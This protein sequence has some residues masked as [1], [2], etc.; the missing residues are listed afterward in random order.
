MLESNKALTIPEQAIHSEAAYTAETLKTGRDA[1]KAIDNLPGTINPQPIQKG[2]TDLIKNAGGQIEKDGATVAWDKDTLAF[3]AKQKQILFNI[4]QQAG[5][6]D[7]MEKAVDL[8]QYISANQPKFSGSGVTQ[9]VRTDFLKLKNSIDSQ[10]NEKA[11]SVGLGDAFSKANE[12][13]RMYVQP[14]H[15]SGAVDRL[16]AVKQESVRQD[17][18]SKNPTAPTPPIGSSYNAAIKQIF[19][20]NPTPQKVREVLSRMDDNG[21]K[22]MEGKFIQETVGD[23]VANP[24]NFNKNSALIKVNQLTEKYKG[25]LSPESMQT[26]DGVKKVLQK[27]GAVARTEGQRSNA[28]AIHMA[29]SA[30]GGGL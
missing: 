20:A 8:R 30:V 7:N 29:G 5:K 18:I 21:K 22:I 24:E 17:F 15:D 27:A 26:L 13:N 3:S 1:Y 6:A 16:D 14:L 9:Q 11:T 28:Y 25:V 4:Q 23:V 12:Y 2:I 19:P 10:I